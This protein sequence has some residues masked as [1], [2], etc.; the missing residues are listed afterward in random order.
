MD[1]GYAWPRALD[2]RSRPTCS[3][4]RRG[5]PAEGVRVA[6]YR[7]DVGQAPIRMTQALTD[8][9]GRVRDLLERPLA[10]G[11]YRLEFD[12][13]RDGRRVLPADRG[14]PRDRRHDA[15]LSRAAPARAVLDDDVPG[16]LSGGS[17]RRR[18]RR[19]AERRVHRRRGAAVRGRAAV[20]GPAGRARARSATRRRSSRRAPTIA[21][22]D[23]RGRAARADRRPPAARRAAGVV[24]A[25]LVPRAG[26]RPRDRPAAIADLERLERARTRRASGSATAS[27]SPAA[28][29]TALVPVLEAALGADR[30]AEI[31]ARARRRRRASPR[32]R[33]GRDRIGRGGSRDRARG[34]PL[35]QVGD[36]ARQGRPRRA[37]AIASAT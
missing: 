37:T 16:Q 4:P 9:D 36:P 18:A 2:R 20:P 3:T 8:G 6:L 21:L 17:G 29:A 26:L 13:G 7:L 33:F 35:R 12:I 24:S 14:R 30:R 27:S 32:D 15:E 34:E 10:A 1:G 19:A 25:A 5:L 31:R 23:A 11:D 28:R 22:R